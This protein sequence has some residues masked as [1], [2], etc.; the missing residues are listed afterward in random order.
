M[1]QLPLAIQPPRES[2]FENFVAGS[3]A[4][5]FEQ[6]RGWRVAGA[7]LYLW[8]PSGSGKTHLLGA[9]ARD[10][11]AR[12]ARTGWFDAGDPLP[13]TVEPDCSL[14]V[15]DRCDELDA[16]AQQAAFALFVD[17]AGREVQ[18]ACAGR[19]P[20]VD[21][22]VREDLRTR[23]G[24]GHVHALVP[25]TEAETRA[26]LRAEARRRGIGLADDVL[27]HLLTRLPRDLAHLMRVLG[28]L[29]DYALAASRAVT[30]PLVRQMLADD[31]APPPV[32]G[33]AARAAGGLVAIG[34][35][36]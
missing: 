20:P 30:V 29:D 25:P 24:W 16:A 1:R 33:P 28:R 2:S 6:L 21:L 10:A 31:A 36:R 13:W 23:L 11:R 4:A 22:P 18:L 15:V 3:N 19:L 17:A 12:G 35:A 9:L 7:P 5:A 8:G 26:V 14:V 34:G 32:G 27:D